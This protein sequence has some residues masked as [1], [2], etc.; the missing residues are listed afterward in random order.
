MKILAVI[1]GEL[2]DVVLMNKEAFDAFSQ[3]G[4]L[5]ALEDFLPQED[6]GLYNAIKPDLAANIVILEDNQEE[7][8]FDSSASYDRGALLRHRPVAHDADRQCRVSRT[9]LLRHR[10]KFTA[11][12]QRRGLFKIPIQLRIVRK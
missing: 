9:R 1:D 8:M 6:S 11:H 7:L 10:C 12:G 2:L 5:Y 4:Y 3:N